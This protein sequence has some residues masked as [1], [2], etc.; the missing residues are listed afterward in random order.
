KVA[1][2]YSAP[3]FHEPNGTG[4]LLISLNRF[5][6]L[7]EDLKRI[8]EHAAAA[9]NAFALAESE[10]Q[11]AAALKA[12]VDEHGVKLRRFPDGLMAAARKAA[13]EMYEEQ[14]AA[15]KGFARTWASYS[16]AIAHLAPWSKTGLESFLA[17]RGG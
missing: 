13:A 12:L 5:T 7:P 8:V 6:A 16:A 9:E 2:Y 3:G 15:D 4:E 11:N 17:A 1:P 14:S 10:W